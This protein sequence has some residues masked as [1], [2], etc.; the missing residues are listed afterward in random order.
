[1]EKDLSQGWVAYWSNHQE[2]GVITIWIQMIFHS[3]IQRICY[4][5]WQGSEKVCTQKSN[6]RTTSQGQQSNTEL[7]F[8]NLL[9]DKMNQLQQDVGASWGWR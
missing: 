9:K 7:L 6:E 4:W 8:C 2:C 3:W 5:S 1:L